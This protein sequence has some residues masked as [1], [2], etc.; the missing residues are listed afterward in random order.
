MP[1]MTCSTKRQHNYTGCGCLVPLESGTQAH[2]SDLPSASRESSSQHSAT[3]NKCAHTCALNICAQH[4]RS[5]HAL[6]TCTQH[7]HSTR[8][9]HMRSTHALN[10]CALNICAQHALSTCAVRAMSRDAAKARAMRVKLQSLYPHVTE[11]QRAV[12]LIACKQHILWL[13]IPVVDPLQHRIISPTH[14]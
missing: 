6:N 9:Q 10:T 7:M 2:P 3:T 13:Q 11:L 12:R 4:M 5:T 14:I 1:P 8:A